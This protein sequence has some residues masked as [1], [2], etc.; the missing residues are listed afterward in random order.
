MDIYNPTQPVYYVYAYLREDYTPYYIGK[1]KGKRLYTKRKSEIQPP[2]D[3]SRIITIQD[4]L[5]E[6]YAFILERYYIR[7]FGRKDN[8]TGILRNRSDGGEG[9]SGLISKRKGMTL[10]QDT[11]KKMSLSKK[12]KPSHRKGKT[13]SDEHKMNLSIAGKGRI[14]WR[15]GIPYTEEEKRKLSEILIGRK[16]TEE[17]KRK[18]SESMK[19]K[20]RLKLLC[21]Y[22]DNMIAAGNYTRWHGDNCKMK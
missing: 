9:P 4:N 15:K 6:V 8:G 3:K 17:H 16:F 7:W 10:S 21:P 18:M 20:I 2:R 22:C 14:G 12:G 13:L 19:G 11:K 5:S 1:G